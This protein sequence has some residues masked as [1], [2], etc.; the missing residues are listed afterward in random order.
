MG[1]AVS[2]NFGSDNFLLDDVSG[3]TGQFNTQFRK[4]VDFQISNDYG[5]K[6]YSSW[7]NKTGWND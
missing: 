4:E 1:K 7:N 6:K 3:A 5:L 2:N